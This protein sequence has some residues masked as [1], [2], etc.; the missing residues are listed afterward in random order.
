M[1]LYM[2]ALLTVFTRSVLCCILFCNIAFANAKEVRYKV[3][4]TSGAIES[5]VVNGDTTGMNWIVRHDGSQYRWITSSDGWGLG[6]FSIGGKEYRWS[7]TAKTATDKSA[8]YQCGDITVTVNRKKC[9]DGLI[10]SYIFTNKGNESVSLTDIG[11]LTPFNDNYPNAKTCV[12]TRCHAHVW[13]GGNTAYVYALRMGAYAPHIGF[14]LTKG[15]ISDYE[16]WHRGNDKGNSQTRGIIALCPDDMILRPGKSESLEWKIFAHDGK[17]DFCNKAT[18]LG[19]NILS[20]DNY[21][22]TPGQDVSIKF[23]SGKTKSIRISDVVGDYRHNIS[24]GNGKSTFADFYV[25]EDKDSLIANRLRF[26]LNNQRMTSSKDARYGAFMIYDCEGDSIYPNDTPNCNPVDR[27][28][29]AER[30]GMGVFAAKYCIAKQ[31]KDKRLISAL[32][33][34][35]RFI[36]TKLQNED[37]K[38]FSSVDKTNRNR[39]YNYAWVSEFYFLMHQITGNAQYAKDGYGTLRSMFDQF[40]H[41]FYAIGIPILLSE[42]CLKNAGMNDEWLL[43]NEDYTEQARIFMKNGLNYP[44]HEVNYEQSIVAPVVQYLAQMYLLTKNPE[45]LEHIKIQMPVMEAFNGFQPSVHLNDIAIRHWDGYWFGK[46]EMYGDVFPHYWSAITASAFHFYS[47]CTGDESWQHRAENIVDNNLCLFMPD[48]KASCA[49]LYPRRVD[50]KPA[51]FY[52]AYANDQDWALAYY[53][54]I[55]ENVW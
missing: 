19:C 35:A 23:Y 49:Y 22:V 29:G 11:I 40:G 51:K 6:Y 20:A 46:S 45:Y 48:G 31:S 32:E 33:D 30:T 53:L 3:N 13:T 14:V 2:L 42:R 44:A 25:V 39:A 54:Q 37:Y 41:G 17:E 34:Y 8:V 1:R 9:D 26:I 7:K 28:E 12:N 38:T 21:L 36:R 52:D 10:E 24:Y 16:I 5:I 27:D 55:K 18:K 43:L 15:S 50:G 47:L 4:Q